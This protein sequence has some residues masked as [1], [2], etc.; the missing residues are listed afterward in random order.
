[1]RRA[2]NPRSIQQ[3]RA[4]VQVALSQAQQVRVQI[5]KATIVS[6]IDGV[7]VNRNLNPGEYPGNR[8]IFTLQQVKPMYAILRG[9][10]AQVEGIASGSHGVDCARRSANV[11]NLP[12]E[13]SACSTKF[14]PARRSFK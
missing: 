4:Q 1:M 8:Q 2:R 14:S 10:A 6:P 7:V 9:S 3:A 13:S 5:A 12:A 11:R